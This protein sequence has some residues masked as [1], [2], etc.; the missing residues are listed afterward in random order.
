MYSNR[1]QKGIKKMNKKEKFIVLDVEGYSTARPYNIGYIV[2]DR[3]GKIY[4]KRSFALHGCIWENIV[5]MVATKQAESMTKRNVEEI[6]ND[7]EKPY[8][9]RKYSHVSIDKFRR[10]WE[11][12]LNKY[13]VKRVFAYNVNFD[14]SSLMRL[15]TAET[16]LNYQL[17]FC[18]IITAILHTKLLTKKYIQFC[19]NNNY[20]TEKKNVMTKAEI[21]YRY[22]TNDLT[23]DEEHTG[24]ADVLIE[25]K[26]LLEAFK[27]H[28]KIETNPCQAWRVLKKF[29]E[30]NEIDLTRG[31]A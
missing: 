8:F 22:L 1:V 5:S 4:K 18:D 6:L 25:Y 2:A 21:V 31:T 30:D 26:I 19:I 11:K 10:F 23:F 9:L 29:C 27:T 24:L 28:Q 3:Y 14:K 13:K 16:L 15:L 12:D 7:T 20:L 17:E